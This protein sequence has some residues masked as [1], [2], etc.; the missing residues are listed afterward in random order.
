MRVQVVP[1]FAGAHPGLT[2]AFTVVSFAEPGA[3]DLV[4]ADTVS[5]KVWLE[6]EADAARHNAIFD[7]LTRLGMARHE[8]LSFIDNIRKEM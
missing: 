7:R 1:F 5:T 4:Q 8:S 6:S 3:L 2:S